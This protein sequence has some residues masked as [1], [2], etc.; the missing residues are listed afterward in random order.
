MANSGEK[1]DLVSILEVKDRNGKVLDKFENSPGEQVLSP[2]TAFII[3][4]ILSDNNA[5]TPAFGSRSELVIEGHPEVAVKTGTTNDLKDN[6]TIGY[7]RLMCCCLG[8]QQQ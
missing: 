8:R 2:E 1:K 3:T 5:R 7:T 4:D 6:W